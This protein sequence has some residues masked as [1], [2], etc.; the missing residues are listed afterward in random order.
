MS[1]AAAVASTLRCRNALVVLGSCPNACTARTLRKMSTDL[2]DKRPSHSRAKRCAARTRRRRRTTTT[3]SRG[4]TRSAAVARARSSANITTS[5]PRSA[6]ASGTRVAKRATSASC[7]RDTS[8][9][10]R[11]TRSPLRFRSWKRGDSTTSRSISDWRRSA[12]TRSAVASERY[13]HR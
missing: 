1:S 3:A 9:V 6:R 10:T 11:L 2:L 4:T 7:T 8:P 13:V 5:I 12:P